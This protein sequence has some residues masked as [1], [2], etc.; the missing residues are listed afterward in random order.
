MVNYQDGKIYQIVNDVNSKIYI[1]ST[2]QTLCRR[3]AV[4]RAFGKGLIHNTPIYIA[5]HEIGV[6]HF[7]IL[8]VRNAP[9]N[10]K[11]ELLAIEYEVA[12][13]FHQRGVILYNAT[14]DGRHSEESRAKMSKAQKGKEKGKIVSEATRAKMSKSRTQRG[15]IR[16]QNKHTRWGFHWY[17]N[18]KQ[19]NKYFSVN[20]YGTKGAH[21]LALYWQE[22]MYPIERE[23]DSE[24]I[25]EIRSRNEA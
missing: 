22:E 14:L 17:E 24:L 4:H 10:G 18:G 8:L 21:G 5:M 16:Y 11:E 15:C 20:K 13:R 7:R 2:C 25:R 9:C 19:Q 1:G 6:E 3:M 23:D 12:Q